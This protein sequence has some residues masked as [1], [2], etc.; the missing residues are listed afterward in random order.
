MLA[1]WL[2]KRSLASEEDDEGCVFIDRDPSHFGAV[3]T[4]LR[5]GPKSALHA[6]GEAEM[7]EMNRELRYCGLPEMKAVVVVFVGVGARLPG[8]I[9]AAHISAYLRIFCN[10]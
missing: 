1:P 4:Y 3:L 8:G 9:C 10:F 6:I 5:E 7:R 2:I